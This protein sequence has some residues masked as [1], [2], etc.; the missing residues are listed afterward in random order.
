MSTELTREEYNKLVQQ[1]EEAS[2][3]NDYSRMIMSGSPIAKAMGKFK[4]DHICPH[5]DIGTDGGGDYCKMC[6]K[7]WNR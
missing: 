6:G 5:P 2:S 3:K 1:Q 4:Q 7:R